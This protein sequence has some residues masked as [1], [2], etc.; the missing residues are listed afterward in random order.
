MT[1][2]HPFTRSIVRNTHY[3]TYK[4]DERNLKKAEI[5]VLIADGYSRKEIAEALGI[6]TTTLRTRM[7]RYGVLFK[8]KK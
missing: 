5:E 6:S 8:G 4:R 3:D 1:Y 7:N 2:A